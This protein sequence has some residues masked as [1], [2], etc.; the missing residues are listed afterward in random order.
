M[1]KLFDVLAVISAILLFTFMMAL[2]SPSNIPII[3]CL[4]TSLY[5][6]I[7]V[8]GVIKHDMVNK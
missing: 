3:T 8:K 4:I 1:K 5:L 7:Y 2:D 6:A